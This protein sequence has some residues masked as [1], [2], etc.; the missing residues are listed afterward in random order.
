MF[1]RGPADAPVAVRAEGVWVEDAEGRRYLDAA[2]GAIV[3]AV[4]HG[5]QEVAE[6]IAR[7]LT[8]LDYVHATAFT[9][10]VLE[11]YANELARLLPVAEARI[12][13][14]SGGSEATE[15]A[16]KLARAYQ[17]ALGQS[18]RTTVLA[19]WG[20]YHGNSL[21]ALDLSGRGPLRRPYEPWLGRFDHLPAVYEYRC[22]NPRHPS[23]CGAWHAG[24]LERR[25]VEGGDVAAFV[26]EPIGG[27]TIGAALPPDD[28]WPA[29]ADVCRRH[30]VLLVVDEVMTGFGRTGRWFASEHYGLRPDILL[31]GK[32]A[33]AGY[34]PLGICVASG[35]VAAAV[36]E[37]GFVHGFTFSHH[38]AGAAAGRQV[39]RIMKEEGL[40]EAAAERGGQLLAAL[41]SSVGGHRAVGDVRGLGLLAAVELVSDRESKAPF[42]RAERVVEQVKGACRESG[43]LV[44]TSTGCVDGVDGDIVLLGPPLTVSEDEVG[45]IVERLAGALGSP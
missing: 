43:L 44:Y 42:P 18:Q 35:N 26:A 9:S 24:E 37:A 30:G 39:L 4:G 38:P 6:A 11:E 12:Y 16:L 19:R 10:D 32:G 23:G 1:R 41:R 14:V 31:A 29:V 25:I 17:L 28:Y 21:G 20:S 7:Q 8:R 33:A 22:P 34:W 40:V 13:P 3:S 2:G 36:A 5:Q 45:M 27:A 15:T